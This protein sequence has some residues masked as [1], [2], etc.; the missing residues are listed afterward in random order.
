MFK[1]VCSLSIANLK[2]T[3][4]MKNP[5]GQYLTQLWQV[6]GQVSMGGQRLTEVGQIAHHC[7]RNVPS[8]P[9]IF[10]ANLYH[11]QERDGAGDGTPPPQV[12]SRF[13]KRRCWRGLKV[14]TAPVAA[15]PVNTY[16]LSKSAERHFDITHGVLKLTHGV[17]KLTFQ[18]YKAYESIRLDEWNTVVSSLFP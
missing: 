1:F 17:L 14:K 9:L 18:E 13:V 15:I 2:L 4:L 8:Y 6:K 5:V 3:V 11:T 12:R 16:F 7:I 10:V